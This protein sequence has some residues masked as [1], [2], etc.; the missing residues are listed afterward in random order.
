MPP[1]IEKITQ[2][3]KNFK[4]R[5]HEE[6]AKLLKEKNTPIFTLLLGVG[7]VVGE[8]AHRAIKAEKEAKSE[9]NGVYDQNQQEQPKIDQKG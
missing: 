7:Y 8:S 4:I 5:Y 6:R 2:D 1:K 3:I 9:G